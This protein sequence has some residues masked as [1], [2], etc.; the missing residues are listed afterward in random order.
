MNVIGNCGCGYEVYC[1]GRLLLFR[2]RFFWGEGGGED[3][4]SES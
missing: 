3:S 4:F 1:I 2:R